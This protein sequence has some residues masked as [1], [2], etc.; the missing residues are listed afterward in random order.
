MEGFIKKTL[1]EY[2]ILSCLA[3]AW[4]PSSILGSPTTSG[5]TLYFLYRFIDK[6]TCFNDAKLIIYLYSVRVGPAIFGY[7]LSIGPPEKLGNFKIFIVIR[8][9]P[10]CNLS[11]NTLKVL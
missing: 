11:T 10:S 7:P 2:I 1:M 3:L 4:P 8:F 6:L 5:Y 9:V